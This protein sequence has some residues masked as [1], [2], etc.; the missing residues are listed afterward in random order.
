MLQRVEDHMGLGF[1]ELDMTW[2]LNNDNP[3][4]LLSGS[5]VIIYVKFLG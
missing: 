5:H 4:D 3:L 1:K 2:Q